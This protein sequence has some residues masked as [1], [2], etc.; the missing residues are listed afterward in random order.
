MTLGFASNQR[1][2][3]KSDELKKRLIESIRTEKK[4]FLQIADDFYAQNERSQESYIEFCQ[5][6]IAAVDHVLSAG[7]WDD[8]LFLHNT[9]KPLKEIRQQAIELLEQMSVATNVQVDIPD[10]SVAADEVKLYIALFQNNGLDL[11]QWEMQLRSIGNYLQGRPVY[12][13]EAD[14]QKALRL[15]Q[16][17]GSE[18][19]IV[20]VVAKSAVHNDPFAPA[21]SDRYGNTLVQLKPGKVTANN[22]REFVHQGQHYNWCQGK[23]KQ[24]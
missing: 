8:S 24:R 16:S 3:A 6:V 10:A 2:K 12:D 13:N 7:N 9:V 19:Y 5:G 1:D 15:K 21:R 11:R 23:L 18:A 14:V 22:I 17:Q 20:V 4:Q